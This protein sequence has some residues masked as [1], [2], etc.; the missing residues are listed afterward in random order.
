M[1]LKF[2]GLI[3]F[4]NCASEKYKN[5]SYRISP[6]LKKRVC[7]IRFISLDFSKYYYL[8]CFKKNKMCNF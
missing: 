7:L 1:K 3:N 6:P 5:H 2:N 8:N 4:F